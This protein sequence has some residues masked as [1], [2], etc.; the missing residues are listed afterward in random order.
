MDG[1]S[2]ISESGQP[3]SAH[4]H[5]RLAS[6]KA[7][8]ARL[9]AKLGE[10]ERENREWSRIGVTLS[11]RKA[12]LEE[13]ASDPIEGMAT[14]EAVVEMLDAA[15]MASSRVVALLQQGVAGG[16]RPRVELGLVPEYRRAMRVASATG[17]RLRARLL[18]EQDLGTLSARLESQLA[19]FATATHQ[20]RELESLVLQSRVAAP[21]VLAHENESLRRLLATVR[22]L[23]ATAA[24]VSAEIR[25]ASPSPPRRRR[26]EPSRSELWERIQMLRL[27]NDQNR[28]ILEAVQGR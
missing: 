26:E 16:Q 2:I 20:L 9:D 8:V 24:H 13:A 3:L 14:S 18:D 15:M 28:R 21:A 23:G 27:E 5:H 10:L 11:A 12:R 6:V 17:E 1:A 22:S 19:C 7:L 4:E 25:S